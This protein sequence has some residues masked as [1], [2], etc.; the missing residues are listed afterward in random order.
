MENFKMSFGFSAV[1][2]GMKSSVVAAEP[3]LIANSTSGKLVIT[4]P[5]SKALNLAP[6][7]YLAFVN[8]I[9]ALEKAVIERIP[10]VVAF[11]E[12]NGIDI[13]TAEGQNEIIEKCT[14]WAIYKGIAKKDKTGNSV[15]VSDRWSKDDK[16]AYIDGHKEEL[17]EKLHDVLVERNDG[18]D[19]DVDTLAEF[20]DVEDI[21]TPKVPE[22]I[23]AKTATTSNATGVG[24]Q[25]NVTDTAIWN[26]LKSDMK[27][28]TAE[29]RVFE[30]KLKDAIKTTINNGYENVDVT[31]YPIEFLADEPKIVR[32]DK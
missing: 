26:Q 30:V 22:F 5:V 12:E 27:D 14:V 9:P 18:N 29:N 13:N 28:K 20:I 32:G 15:L 2:N 21:E 8:N 19:A 6:G 4:S 17:V 11:A 3:R 23:G 7:E 25:L 1:Q 24:C 10:D 16:A 31:A